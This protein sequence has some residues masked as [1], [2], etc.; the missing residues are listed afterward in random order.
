MTVAQTGQNLPAT[1]SQYAYSDEDDDG[2]GDLST[3]DLVIPRLKIVG[4]EALFQDTLSNEQF[5]VVEV[6]ILGLIKQRILWHP[7]VDKDDKPMCKSNDFAIGVPT[8]ADNP[9]NKLFPWKSSNFTPEAA[10]INPTLPTGQQLDTNGHKVLPCGACK[11]KE[12]DTHPNGGKPWC[13]ELHTLPVMYRKPAE[14]NA[15]VNPWTLAILQF[16]S[17]G[18]GA[19]KKYLSNFK[20][21]NQAPFTAITRISLQLQSRG[22]TI[23]STPILQRV[24]DTDKVDWPEYSE[25]YRSVR[26]YARQLPRP[27][28]PTDNDSDGAP[29]EQMGANVWGPAVIQQTALAQGAAPVTESSVAHPVAEPV[30]ATEPDPAPEPEAPAAQAAPTPPPAPA[31]AAPAPVAQA[32]VAPP[33]PAPA[34]Q[35]PTPPAAPA[36][37]ATPAADP[38]ALPF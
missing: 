5:P 13:N 15:E 30:Q 7:T 11:F 17:S 3:A 23:Y 22:D 16:K 8:L 10:Q 18:L 33:T 21:A 36:P 25:S 35:A 14:P 31:P 1:A 4:K 20:R 37:A 28:D 12:W 32:P 19:S 38:N 6:V 9:A 29:A 26:D 2:L 27:N 24:G 34:A